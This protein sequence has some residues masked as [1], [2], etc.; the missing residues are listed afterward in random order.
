MQNVANIAIIT[1]GLRA[2]LDLFFATKGQ[3]VNAYAMRRGRLAE[4]ARLD[5]M[6]DTELGRL[7]I[8]RAEIPTHVFRDI[9]SV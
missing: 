2:Q 4:L 7:G 5:A 8:T 3:G 1:P 6:S 9:F